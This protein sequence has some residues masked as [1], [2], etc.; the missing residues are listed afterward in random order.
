M[1]TEPGLNPTLDLASNSCYIKVEKIFGFASKLFKIHALPLLLLI[2]I[3]VSIVPKPALPTFI[4]LSIITYSVGVYL[5]YKFFKKRF[6]TST[7][8]IVILVASLLTSF[9]CIF[10]YFPVNPDA[11]PN[12]DIFNNYPKNPDEHANDPEVY[13]R[14]AKNIITFREYG[15]DTAEN[16]NR[17]LYPTAFRPVG[18][19]LY[20]ASVYSIFRGF[21]YRKVVLIQFLLHLIAILFLWKLLRKHFNE[22][23]ANLAILL[24]SFNL[25]LLFVSNNLWSETFAQALI[26]FFSFLYLR[27]KGNLLSILTGILGAWLILTRPT[28]LIYL[29]VLFLDTAKNLKT[30]KLLINRVITLLVVIGICGAWSLRNSILAERFTL[31]A[32]NGGINIFLGNNPYVFNGRAAFWPPKDYVED[33]LQLDLKDKSIPEIHRN[34]GFKGI[35]RERA[36]DAN[37]TSAALKWIREN[38]K[39]FMRLAINKIQFLLSPDFHLF[40]GIEELNSL[41]TDQYAFL[42]FLQTVYFWIFLFLSILGSFDKRAK[43]L[44]LLSLPYLFMIILTFSETR[45]QIPLYIPMAVLASLGALRLRRIKIKQLPKDLILTIVLFSSQLLLFK[46][47]ILEPWNHLLFEHQKVAAAYNF[48]G[49]SNRSVLYLIEAKQEGFKD[50]FII[51]NYKTFPDARSEYAYLTY[52]GEVVDV[53]KMKDLLKAR[54]T[55][56]ANIDIFSGLP[57]DFLDNF[58]LQYSYKKGLAIFSIEPRE[59]LDSKEQVLLAKSLASD[60]IS[61]EKEVL[62]GKLD[63]KA[64]LV[65]LEVTIF[66]NSE[67]KIRG[68]ENLVFKSYP[69]FRPMI[70]STLYFPATFFKDGISIKIN[71]RPFPNSTHHLSIDTLNRDSWK[72][73]NVEVRDVTA[74]Y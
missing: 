14:L 27:T 74:I 2:L 47:T 68:E 35:K 71:N 43:V 73:S 5:Y 7:L 33:V 67:V 11:H 38:P 50:R 8:L 70:K 37:Y 13:D 40:G 66:K 17:S 46:N 62:S 28:Y 52:K 58:Y 23:T 49:T 1:L 57:A 18:Y 19:P 45:F 44:L 21:D 54:I 63:G 29:P 26:I 61:Q 15:Q 60:W 53:E 3:E 20:I 4:S 24:Y 36:N 64:K 31:I 55:Y 39:R 51:K 41:R 9:F 69:R 22:K 6:N 34:I 32:T 16:S 25:P 59:Q 42:I 72:V 30:K 56:T 10:N 12:R 65:S 48:I